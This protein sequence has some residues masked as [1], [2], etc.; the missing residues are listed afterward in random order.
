MASK[1]KDAV[2]WYQK[3][4]RP[5]AFCGVCMLTWF[6]HLTQKVRLYKNVMFLFVQYIICRTPPPQKRKK[7]ITILKW[8]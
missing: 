4:V 7:R 1:V 8:K 3:K 6:L 5:C 2:V